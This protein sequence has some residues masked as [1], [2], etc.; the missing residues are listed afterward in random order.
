M[1]L[2]RE[3]SRHV[4]SRAFALSGG[5]VVPPWREKPTEGGGWASSGWLVPT[6][7]GSHQ[8]GAHKKRAETYSH[9]PAGSL[10][11]SN[12]FRRFLFFGCCCLLLLCFPGLLMHWS[13]KPHMIAQTSFGKSARVSPNIPFVP[14]M[15]KYFNCYKSLKSSSGVPF[16]AS[17]RQ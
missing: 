15:I 16:V 11:Q 6:V 17:L 2:C 4:S 10:S 9:R 5:M 13:Q 8:T 1:P 3:T 7:S 12:Y 14:L